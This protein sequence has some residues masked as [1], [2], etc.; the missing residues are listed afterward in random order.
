MKRHVKILASTGL[1]GLHVVAGFSGSAVAQTLET[2]T[3]TGTRDTG[4]WPNCGDYYS[5]GGNRPSG[6]GSSV[7]ENEAFR[8]PPAPPPAKSAEQK[9]AEREKCESD[10]ID[11]RAEVTVSYNANMSVCAARNSNL[12]GYGEQMVKLFLADI[13]KKPFIDC[14]GQ[15]TGEYNMTLN[16]IDSRRNTCVAAADKG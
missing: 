11:A 14:A 5:N 6:S 8:G 15:L 2:V 3:V 12:L 1:L 16:I 7:P 10:R 9:K 13:T 4:C